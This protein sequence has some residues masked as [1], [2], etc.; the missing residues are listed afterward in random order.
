MCSLFQIRHCNEWPIRRLAKASKRN[1]HFRRVPAD[2]GIVGGDSRP[3]PT[4]IAMI[5]E[6]KMVEAVEAVG[7]VEGLVEGCPQP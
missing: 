7:L 6:R 1:P 3:S 5:P 2:G 4:P